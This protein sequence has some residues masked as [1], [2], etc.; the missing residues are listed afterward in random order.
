[1]LCTVASVWK[2]FVRF[3]IVICDLLH[4]Q[5]VQLECFE[6]SVPH[7]DINLCEFRNDFSLSNLAASQ[8]RGAQVVQVFFELRMS[9]GTFVCSGPDPTLRKQ[10]RCSDRDFSV[11]LVRS[12]FCIIVIDIPARVQYSTEVRCYS[13]PYN[14]IFP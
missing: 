11:K 7:L 2:R 6:H 13:P 3:L 4:A 1:M 14:H 9:T 5:F 10:A 8:L 12:P